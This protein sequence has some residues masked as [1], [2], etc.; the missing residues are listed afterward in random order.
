MTT[1]NKEL[2]AAHQETLRQRRKK[3]GLKRLELWIKP[4]WESIIKGLVEV[5]RRQ[6][7][8]IPS[9]LQAQKKKKED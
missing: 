5:L 2:N 4:A 3:Q 9:A 6:T 8:H 1:P 7:P